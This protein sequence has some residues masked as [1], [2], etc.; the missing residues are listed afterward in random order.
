MWQYDEPIK[1]IVKVSPT[2]V[3]SIVEDPN[4]ET[5]LN[6]D[7]MKKNKLNKL[8]SMQPS[9]LNHPIKF[10]NANTNTYSSTAKINNSGIKYN[11]SSGI[12]TTDLAEKKQ[13]MIPTKLNM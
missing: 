13:V 9:P 10:G 2:K 11:R 12:S 1:A 7:M 4:K 5:L 3:E 8:E 6:F